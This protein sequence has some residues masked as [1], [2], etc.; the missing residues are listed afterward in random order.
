MAK[1]DAYDRLTYESVENDCHC[2][3]G[4]HAEDCLGSVPFAVYKH[5]P[6]ILEVAHRAREELHE[7]VRQAITGQHFHRILFDRRYSP[8]Q[9]LQMKKRLRIIQILPIYYRNQNGMKSRHSHI[10]YFI[11]YLMTPPITI[12]YT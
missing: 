3:C 1:T 11:Y 7:G 6:D 4:N 12:Y 10:I 5:Q 9:S 8:V 2:S